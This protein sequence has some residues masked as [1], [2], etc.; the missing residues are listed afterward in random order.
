MFHIHH[1]IWIY[2]QQDE[3]VMIIEAIEHPARRLFMVN[4]NIAN[5]FD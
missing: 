3:N 1:K 5:K 2:Q 4:L